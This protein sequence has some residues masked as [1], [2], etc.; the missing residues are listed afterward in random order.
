MS[1]KQFSQSEAMLQQAL[2]TVPLGSQTF[3][4]SLL[5]FPKGV[6]PYFAK[7]GKGCILTDVDGNQYTDFISA[8]LC[9]SLGYADE[10]VNAAVIEQIHQGSI[11]SVPHQLEFEVAELLCELIP[12]AE[13]VRFGKN[14]SDAT[15]AA[16]RLARA[17]TGNDRVAVCGYH[18]WQDWYIGSTTR[19]LGVPQK[20]KDLTHAFTYN[21][22]DSLKKVLSEHQGEFAAVIMEPM[23]TVFP[24]NDF[25]AKVKDLAHQHG[26]LFIF[27]ETITGFRFDMGGAQKLFGVT[28]DLSTVG[29]GMANGYPISAIVGRADVMTLMED[30]FFSGTFGGDTVALAAAKA[31][32]NKMRRENVIE[33]I[34]TLGTHLKS[35]LTALIEQLELQQMF[36]T[37]GHPSWSFLL[38]NHGKNHDIWTVRTYLMQELIAAGFLSNGS[39]NLNFSHQMAHI[40][41]L[42]ETYA[43]ILP[44]IKHFDEQ[45]TLTQQLRCPVLEPIFKVR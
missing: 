2:K 34:H 6:S 44:K 45:G 19:S 14:G 30:I 11:F 22:I 37:T 17:F 35:K 40:D 39:H 20:T 32:I 8:L 3:S 16:I 41:A 28:P 29:K 24:E 23:N 31:C 36:M 12:C 43:E 27:D 42:I 25:L 33:H 15:S 4:K 7:Q 5:A 13:M 18:G 9:I 38:N 21:N 10:E 26:A 1:I